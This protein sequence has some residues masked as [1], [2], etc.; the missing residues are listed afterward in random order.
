MLKQSLLRGVQRARLSN[1]RSTSTTS[2]PQKYKVLVIG[3]GETPLR[4]ADLTSYQ[5]LIPLFVSLPGSGG[6][7]VAQQIYNRFEVAG[8]RLNSGDVAIVDGAENHYY[9]VM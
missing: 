3:G 7:T 1:A 6:L 4:T 8:K 5:S 2:T 9:Q